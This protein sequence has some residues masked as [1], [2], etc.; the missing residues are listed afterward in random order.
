MSPDPGRWRE[1]DRV[2]TDHLERVPSKLIILRV[3]K[4]V[5]VISRATAAVSCAAF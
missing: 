2:S 4:P 3:T 5:Y 1:I